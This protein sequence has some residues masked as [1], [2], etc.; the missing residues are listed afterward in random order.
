MDTGKLIKEKRQQAGLSHAKLAEKAG[1][2]K[3]ALIYWEQGRD[4]SVINLEKV[5]NALGMELK[6]S[7]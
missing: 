5:L 7:A 2:S 4:I 3:R 1:V 6:I